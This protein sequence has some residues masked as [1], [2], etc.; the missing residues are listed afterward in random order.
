MKSRIVKPEEVKAERP[1]PKLMISKWGSIV[2][3]VK[4]ARGYC[5]FV[6]E[7]SGQC[8]GEYSYGW[9]MNVFSDFTGTIELS[10]D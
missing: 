2:I 1:F 6:G 3:M 8:I 4:S 5:V 7:E 10:N 9:D